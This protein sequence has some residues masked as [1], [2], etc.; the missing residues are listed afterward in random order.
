MDTAPVQ[1]IVITVLQILYVFIRSWKLLIRLKRKQRSVSLLTFSL[2]IQTVAIR[3]SWNF[4]RLF[5]VLFPLCH[6]YYPINL[7]M[8]KW[9]TFCFVNL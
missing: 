4:L 7:R 3:Q 5:L 6:S 8:N 2:L 1:V 9:S